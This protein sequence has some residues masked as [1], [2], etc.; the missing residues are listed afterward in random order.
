MA[1]FP[2]TLSSLIGEVRRWIEDMPAQD[3]LTGSVTATQTTLPVANL[4][5]WPFGA[6]VEIDDEM[7]YVTSDQT[8]L[9]GPGNVTV[10][11]GFVWTTAATHASGVA[12]YRDVRFLKANVREAVNIVIHD[13]CSFYFPQLVEDTVT[14][15]TA[16]PIKW[17]VPAPADAL[18]IVRVY[19]QIPGF[20]RY[21]D[22]P[23]TNLR[24]Y[25]Q[26]DINASGSNL[27][28]T[29]ALG[30][31]M[32]EQPLPGRIIKV[33]YEKRWPYL[34]ADTDTVPVDFPEEAQDLVV[35]GAAH[36]LSG[37]RMLPK[38]TTSEIVWH[39]EQAAPMP[40][41]LST[42]FYQ[43]NVNEWEKRARQIRARRPIEWPH[44]QYVGMA[45][46]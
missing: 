22:V 13:W 23:V 7:V 16:N 27:G 41:N 20:S 2:A 37:W 14:G 45:M 4:N 18:A 19:W 1:F 44:K 38:F 29:G 9:S 28:A 8:G 33:L 24:F 25:P 12:C 21:V 36:Y 46:L 43:L 32:Y 5:L 39:R 11:R 3:T 6:R 15:G 42:A 34:T 40:P 10:V 30:F 31:E 26:A 35:Q 17:F